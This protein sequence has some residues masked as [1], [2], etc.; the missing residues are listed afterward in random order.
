MIV[1]KRAD[2]TVVRPA[3][4]CKACTCC[5]Q[6]KP[7]S[8]YNANKRAPD[9]MRQSCRACATDKTRN[10]RAANPERYKASAK[11]TAANYVANFRGGRRAMGLKYTYGITLSEWEAL[12]DVQGRRCAIC[13]SEK[14]HR[15]KAIWHTD[16]DHATGKVRG[17]LCSHCNLGLGLFGEEISGLQRAIDY[18]KDNS[19]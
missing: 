16:H 12:F 13:K 5:K 19:R 14:P 6:V 18:L 4:P 17:I 7:L 8:A 9:G 10:W 3:E 15:K 1:I 11:V 2:A